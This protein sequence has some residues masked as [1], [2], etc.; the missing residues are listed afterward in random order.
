MSGENLGESNYPS[1]SAGM[2]EVQRLQGQLLGTI[3]EMDSKI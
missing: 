3:S 2:S 1:A